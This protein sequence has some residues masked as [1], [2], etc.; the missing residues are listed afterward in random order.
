MRFHY[1]FNPLVYFS[2][3][4]VGLESYSWFLLGYEEFART[5]EAG[6]LMRE[7]TRECYQIDFTTS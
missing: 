4:S 6:K 1:I 7:V 3:K 5:L 2:G